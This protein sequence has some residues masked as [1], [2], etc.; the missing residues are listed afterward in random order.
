MI[1]IRS[2]LPERL[3]E[4]FAGETQDSIGQKFGAGQGTVSKWLSGETIV[5]T[6]ILLLIAEAYKV[7]VDWLLGL[8]ESVYEPATAR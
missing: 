3:K 6:E 1:D 8:S 4:L 7:S 2:V 5:P